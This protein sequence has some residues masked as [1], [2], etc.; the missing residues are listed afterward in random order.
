M[1]FVYYY[2]NLHIHFWQLC[3]LD[4]V[5]AGLPDY[6]FVNLW[7]INKWH[8]CKVLFHNND[9][10]FFHN[11]WI[12]C[13]FDGLCL[14]S[15]RSLPWITGSKVASK[16]TSTNSPLEATKSLR[17]FDFLILTLV[18]PS[19]FSYFP[20]VHILQ[21]AVKG[22]QKIMAMKVTKSQKMSLD[23]FQNNLKKLLYWQIS[24]FQIC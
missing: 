4:V 7:I 20:S 24:F 12:Q 2:T 23:I 10:F 3:S 8:F 19:E 21:R 1:P 9:W 15:N 14:R 17:R 6:G 16:M 22:C 11:I 5:A 18:L 13:R